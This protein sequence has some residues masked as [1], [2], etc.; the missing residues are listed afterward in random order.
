MPIYEYRCRDCH[1]LTEALRSMSQADD[2]IACGHCGK[3]HT[4]RVLSVF[5]V[6]GSSDAGSSCGMDG[7]CG[8]AGGGGHSGG[9][10]CCGGVCRHHH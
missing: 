5:A 10:G 4:Q 6:A 2:P 8:H 9:G 7:S 3:K 1:H